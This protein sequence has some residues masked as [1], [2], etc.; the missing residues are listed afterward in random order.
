[1]MGQSVDSISLDDMRALAL[2]VRSRSITAAAR[3]LG[4]SKQ[5]VSRRLSALET[6]IGAPLLHRTTRNVRPTELGRSYARRCDQVVTLAREANEDVLALTGDEQLRITADR[7]LF[8]AF[9]AE[10]V[11]SFAKQYPN[12]DIELI[13][14]PSLVDLD[15]EQIDLAFRVGNA[16]VPDGYHRTELGPAEIC[17]CASPEY[18]RRRG[19]PRHP[20]D[21][22][23][24]DCVH[25]DEPGWPI[26]SPSGKVHVRPLQRRYRLGSFPAARRAVLAGV[27]IGLFPVFAAKPLLENGVLQTV[28]DDWSGTVGT[29]SLLHCTARVKPPAL[30]FVHLAHAT[31]AQSV[32]A[33]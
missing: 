32:L 4:C 21:L 24:H 16:P 23:Q 19:I 14:T 18:L 22:R 31:Y 7:L 29:I 8:E 11:V 1:M 12:V 9:V 15:S 20:D 13:Q 27:G 25:G 10:L 26:V 33:V 2:V 28:L 3:E 30:A 6:P 5:T 17:Y